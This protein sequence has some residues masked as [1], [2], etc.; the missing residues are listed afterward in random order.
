MTQNGRSLRLTL[1]TTGPTSIELGYGQ[2]AS[3]AQVIELARA[4]YITGNDAFWR[5]HL[6]ARAPLAAGR[7]FQVP[8]SA[9]RTAISAFGHFAPATFSRC[10]PEDHGT[11]RL[12]GMATVNGQRAILIKDAGNVPGSTP[13]EFAV[14]ATGP[15]YPLRATA[16]GRSRAGG[17]IDACNDGKPSTSLGTITFGD[18]GRV[19]PIRPP[20]VIANR[21][22]VPAG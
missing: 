4:F 20:A 9:M 6:G 1:I 21:G 19:P 22:A 14:A 10:I 16:L 11:L 8:P 17:R 5:P 2:G 12:A 3:F 15:P 13:S 7:W 18:F